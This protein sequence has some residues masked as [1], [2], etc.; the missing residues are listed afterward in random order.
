MWRR[1]NFK[2][3]PSRG[4]WK[5]AK[6]WDRWVDKPPSTTSSRRCPTSTST[7]K[8]RRSGWKKGT[9]PPTP[10]DQGVLPQPTWPKGSP[11]IL[12]KKPIT[13]N[14]PFYSNSFISFGTRLSSW[15]HR[16]TNV[17]ADSCPCY[18]NLS[19]LSPLPTFL[20]LHPLPSAFYSGWTA[21][22]RPVFCDLLPFPTQFLSSSIFSGSFLGGF[23]MPNSLF[24]SSNMN[25]LI[26][27]C[28]ISN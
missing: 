26:R 23:L 2:S 5:S 8:T 19:S 25:I 3:F 7:T 24:W 22:L 9:T 18:P 6:G 4:R 15:L 28:C 16:Q 12:S 10:K 11:A 13:I 17:S 1:P 20:I 21:S 27:S 14:D